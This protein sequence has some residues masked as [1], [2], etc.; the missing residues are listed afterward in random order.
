M[1]TYDK[2]LETI[3]KIIKELHPRLEEKKLNPH[4]ELTEKLE[5]NPV[6]IKN[7]LFSLE[8]TFHAQ[9]LFKE[10]GIEPSDRITIALLADAI[11][12]ELYP[13]KLEAVGIYR[14]LPCPR[15]LILVDRVIDLGFL[16]LPPYIEAF[17]NAPASAWWASPKN[18]AMPVAFILEGLHQTAYILL[19]FLY[20]RQRMFSLLSFGETTSHRLVKPGDKV[21]YYVKY[22]EL[23]S[24]TQHKLQATALVNDFSCLETEIILS[25]E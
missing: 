23:I 9:G 25:T 15:E 18:T 21:K 14:V 5:L 4:T 7:I 16:L 2:I 22:M 13:T 11:T 8:D 20:P 12:K 6:K 1:L 19:H 10:K 17:Y 24:A 3:V